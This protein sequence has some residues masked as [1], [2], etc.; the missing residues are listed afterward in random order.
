MEDLR[1]PR[2]VVDAVARDVENIRGKRDSRRG[3]RR[4][5]S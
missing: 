4:R 3:V 1:D 2:W 5:E